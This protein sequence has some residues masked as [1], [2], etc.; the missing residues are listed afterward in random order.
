MPN[1]SKLGFTI[2]ILLSAVFKYSI[3]L[4][5]TPIRCDCKFERFIKT[6]KFA[7]KGVHN[8]ICKDPPLLREN[9]I[10]D[11]SE[12]LLKCAISMKNGCPPECNCYE[13]PSRS[14]VVVNCS[15]TR[16]Y[17]MPS[18]CLQQDD[19]DINLSHNF[20]SVFEYRTF[21]NRTFSIN[22]SNNRITS[23]DPF[24]YGIMKLRN[25]NL[26]HNKIVQIHKNVLL[27]RNDHT[28][29]FGRISIK[30]SCKMK[31]IGSWLENQ[32]R[33]H[34]VN[35]SIN[36]HIRGRDIQASSIS[37]MCSFVKPNSTVK[38]VLLS[39]MISICVSLMLC[40]KMKY[41]LC[42]LLMNF[43]GLY[44]NNYDN[45]EPTRFDVYISCNAE[46][47]SI[48]KWIKT[49]VFNLETSGFKICWPPRDFNVG[50]VHVVKFRPK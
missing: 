23:V 27:M 46:N 47:D 18:V 1:L 11:I 40:L 37:K 35:N 43:K 13:Q 22:F 25:I 34:G 42:L 48:M 6:I 44:L 29:S 19:L 21:L 31:W 32:H 41:E 49:V 10:V 36:C 24:V 16:K 38:Y 17:K 2:D 28:I 33:R 15:S 20:I 8:L 45:L 4:K 26:Q 7:A 50:D 9:R 39:F 14:R 5:E 30:C 3:N 12:D